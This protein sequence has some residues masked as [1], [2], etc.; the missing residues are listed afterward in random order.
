[1]NVTLTRD[2]EE[3]VTSQVKSG[4][5]SSPSEVVGNAL[6]SQIEQSM[7]ETFEARLER[8]EEQIRR[9]EF[10]LADNDFYE[11]KKEMIRQKYL[12]A[13]YQQIKL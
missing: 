12:N 8:G 1:M 3:Y 13:H 2:M 7:M 11:R 6:K 10:V 9:G 5:F 4:K